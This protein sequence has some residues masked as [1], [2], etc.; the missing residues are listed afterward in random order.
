MVSPHFEDF[1]G[2]AFQ[3]AI[4]IRAYLCLSDRQADPYETH[5]NDGQITAGHLVWNH[6]VALHNSNWALRHCAAGLSEESEVDALIFSA[7]THVAHLLDFLE[8]KLPVS[9]IAAMGMDEFLETAVRT[10]A[11]F[12]MVVGSWQTIRHM[13]KQ[14]GNDQKRNVS[15]AAARSAGIAAAA[16]RVLYEAL[17]LESANESSPDGQRLARTPTPP[18]INML[19]PHERAIL[20]DWHKQEQEPCRYTLMADAGTNSFLLGCYMVRGWLEKMQDNK[21][22]VFIPPNCFKSEIDKTVRA[23]ADVSPEDPKLVVEHFDSM[24]PI[25]I[26]GMV[27][28]LQ[29]DYAQMLA[30]RF[31]DFYKDHPPKRLLVS[32]NPTG[33]WIDP[34][35]GMMELTYHSAPAPL[36]WNVVPAAG[37]GQQRFKDLRHNDWYDN[38]VTLFN[39]HSPVSD[40]YL[41][42]MYLSILASEMMSHD[43]LPDDF[44]TTGKVGQYMKTIR[45]RERRG[46]EVEHLLD[47][48]REHPENLRGSFSHIMF[49]LVRNGILRLP[50]YA[51]EPD[52]FEQAQRFRDAVLPIA[53]KLLEDEGLMDP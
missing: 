12:E 1:L 18:D 3:E 20:D 7:L 51:S 48:L 47:S 21:A 38:L 8:G 17:L 16:W 50:D 27:W 34:P 41:V 52:L 9:S 6:F 26:E 33:E 4:R 19:D 14:T 2:D 24:N 22:F 36:Y 15:H 5:A 39:Q 10:Q 53:T 11:V 40:H 32:H 45:R 29:I 46:M 13:F 30:Q 37:K 35:V 44:W 42:C 28:L 43:E 49:E 23:V 25:E 31:L